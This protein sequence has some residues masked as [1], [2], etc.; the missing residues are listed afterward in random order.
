MLT[1]ENLHFSMLNKKAPED[2]V[3][4]T[5]VNWAGCIFKLTKFHNE[6]VIVAWSLELTVDHHTYKWQAYGIL[7][8]TQIQVF[9]A[10]RWKQYFYI[11]KL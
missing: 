7:Q 11:M 1:A 4:E 2:S 5:R 3:N 6:V 9:L 10:F 8:K